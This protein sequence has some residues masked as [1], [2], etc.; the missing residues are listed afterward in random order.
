MGAV[1]RAR[2]RPGP[3]RGGGAATHRAPAGRAA[4]RGL[5]PGLAP[6]RAAG[7]VA[8]RRGAGGV[9]RPAAG[10]DRLLLRRPP[11]GPPRPAL[12]GPQRQPG[13]LPRGAPGGHQLRRGVPAGARRAGDPPDPRRARQR[14]GGGGRLRAV[15]APKCGPLGPAPLVRG[16]GPGG[17]RGPRGLAALPA[18]PGPGRRRRARG[19][20]PGRLPRRG[21]AAGGGARV[22]HLRLLPGLV[23][24]LDP[25]RAA[26]LRLRPPGK[27][28]ALPGAGGAAPPAH[29][30]TPGGVFSVSHSPQGVAFSSYGGLGL[31]V[32]R[33]ER[34]PEGLEVGSLQASEPPAPALPQGE[35]VPGRALHPA[36]AAALL[37]AGGARGLRAGGH[38]LRQRRGRAPRL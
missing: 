8:G 22:R 23:A 31:E 14:R 37:A 20:A 24:R 7:L 34:L 33:L 2:A 18:R 1:E 17:L 27:L 25:R 30:P 4:E 36:P 28:P 5:E 13:L 15:R 12:L 35:A 26:P 32:K 16:A 11:A 19:V 21:A 6:R 10:H 9:G 3:G 38:G 29:R